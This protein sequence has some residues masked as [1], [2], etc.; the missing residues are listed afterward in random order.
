MNLQRRRFSAK[1]HKIMATPPPSRRHS[2]LNPDLHSPRS[3]SSRSLVSNSI[4]ES[5]ARPHVRNNLTETVSLSNRSMSSDTAAQELDNLIEE[6]AN[7]SSISMMTLSCMER[8]KFL[9]EYEALRHNVERLIETSA[10]MSRV[11]NKSTA[12]HISAMAVDLFQRERKA[13]LHLLKFRAESD[14]QLSRRK[15]Q[16]S[17]ARALLRTVR[18]ALYVSLRRRWSRWVRISWLSCRRRE[19][20]MLE[21]RRLIDLRQ[22]ARMRREGIVRAHHKSGLRRVRRCVS[23]WRYHVL[24]CTKA[25]RLLRRLIHMK[26]VDALSRWRAV[27]ALKTHFDDLVAAGS[28]K[29]ARAVRLRCFYSWQRAITAQ[30]VCRVRRRSCHRLVKCMKQAVTLHKWFRVTANE[31]Y[32]EAVS[33]HKLLCRALI[34]MHTQSRT[35]RTLRKHVRRL[36]LRRHRHVVLNAVLHWR[37][38]TNGIRVHQ[39]IARSTMRRLTRVRAMR[40][41]RALNINAKSRA[42]M[43]AV[44]VGLLRRTRRC[45]LRLRVSKWK[46]IVTQYGM[47]L[48]TLKRKC[49]REVRDMFW[50]WVKLIRRS[51]LV[52]RVV[53][54]WSRSARARAT[55]AWARWTLKLRELVFRTR[56]L[57]LA[58]RIWLRQKL[59]SAF[60]EWWRTIEELRMHDL[61]QEF[62]RKE[63]I[64]HRRFALKFIVKAYNAR[65]RQ[66]Q[67]SSF[68]KWR[69]AA[70]ENRRLKVEDT[71]RA[72]NLLA[73]VTRLCVRFKKAM[74]ALAFATW[75]QMQAQHVNGLLN[76]LRYEAEA[77]KERRARALISRW[78]R[79]R[80]R[81]GFQ[82]WRFVHV[83]CKKISAYQVQQLSVVE[84]SA[85]Q[86][87]RLTLVCALRTWKVFSIVSAQLQACVSHMQGEVR[88][89]A[90][91]RKAASVIALMN[92]SVRHLH[93]QILA[94]AI[95]RW[96]LITC[97]YWTVRVTRL[98]TLMGR[99]MMSRLRQAQY[100]ALRIWY[101]KSSRKRMQGVATKRVFTYTSRRRTYIAFYVWYRKAMRLKTLYLQILQVAQRLRKTRHLLFRDALSCWCYATT[102]SRQIV[103]FCSVLAVAFVSCR[104]TMLGSLR[105]WCNFTLACRAAD[106]VRKKRILQVLEWNVQAHQA[107]RIQII[108]LLNRKCNAL[109]KFGLF[110]WQQFVCMRA[111]RRNA[112]A[113]ASLAMRFMRFK[114]FSQAVAIWRRYVSSLRK[115]EKVLVRQALSLHEVRC[116]PDHDRSSTLR[117]GLSGALSAVARRS[118]TPAD[119]F[120]VR[121][122]VLEAF[123]RGASARSDHRLLQTVF[124]AWRQLAADRRACLTLLVRLSRRRA[125]QSLCRALHTWELIKEQCDA[126]ERLV[127]SFQTQRTLRFVASL[128]YRWLR[129]CTTKKIQF[130]FG[131]AEER[132]FIKLAAS[133][134]FSAWAALTAERRRIRG[135]VRRAARLPE[136]R[137]VAEYIRELLALPTNR[138]S[139]PPKPEMG[140]Y[141]RL[142]RGRSQIPRTLYGD[143]RHRINDPRAIRGLDYDD[144]PG[145]AMRANLFDEPVG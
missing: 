25:R 142:L 80:L 130:I 141:E 36:I 2:L 22:K 18:R 135:M 104:R 43:R 17:G 70:Y 144:V 61:T 72:V 103:I 49:A 55:W 30:K 9:P 46:V 60:R 98:R 62:S 19:R 108:K 106:T 20:A 44:F 95:A 27:A 13:F 86:R 136:Q 41:F 140:S 40:V 63:V 28:A 92:A 37:A 94:R 137:E 6:L 132:S 113:L 79:I 1:R 53:A 52:R 35:F 65:S 11:E 77:H 48:R 56:I 31:R 89:M 21:A 39:F 127:L 66:Q 24:K 116:K 74:C 51:N 115:L 33:G 97:S 78:L 133:K 138:A 50:R 90:L 119:L 16:R 58:C 88:D 83:A 128:F 69:Q 131:V 15:L 114:I 5:T 111:L 42:L 120:R 123:K 96:R 139:V 110:A 118:S 84:K 124:G 87:M 109:L 105:K 8:D 7:G 129:M 64:L 12:L 3:S 93:S 75:R 112:Q 45:I 29:R 23:A 125:S 99:A 14:A 47:L 34:T 102:R 71:L 67:L 32:A 126:K 57:T 68:T 145:I 107:S 82:L 38:A 81:A 121:A 117:A 10:K 101:A 4:N 134:S 122:G 91:Q 54:R 143:G 73:V 59:R 100:L 76:T 26:R 85:R